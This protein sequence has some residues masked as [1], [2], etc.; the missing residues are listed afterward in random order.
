MAK[1]LKSL[2]V[3]LLVLAIAAL[4]LGNML[5]LQREELKGR[6]Q[7]LEL[8]VMQ[9][10][11][12]VE[13][14]APAPATDPDYP[15]RDV[16]MVAAE[17]DENPERGDFWETYY[18]DL[19]LAAESTLDLA[20]KRDQL[21]RY[22]RMDPITQKPMR[23]PVTREKVTD[24][25]DTMQALLDGVIDKASGQLDRLNRTRHE[26]RKT[27][28]ELV[29]TVDALN[30]R[31]GELRTALV[32]IVDRDCSITRLEDTVRQRDGTIEECRDEIVMLGDTIHDQ[33][34][35]L[36]DRE[37]DIFSLNQTV[38]AQQ[39]KIHE[40]ESDQKNIVGVNREWVWITRGIKGNIAAI[41]EEMNFVVIEFSTEFISE[42]TRALEKEATRPDPDMLV[43]RSQSENPELFV[44]KVKLCHVNP[45]TCL[46][47]ATIL[48]GWQQLQ[49]LPG[50]VV[51]Y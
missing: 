30:T 49:I 14:G 23:D 4:T 2:V 26:L 47:V 44:T 18:H 48:T 19:E 27:R 15:K 42:Y 22:F 13:A 32:A 5:F 12:T 51:A 24:G 3:V 35:T 25:P 9:M 8:A 16:G 6:T 11:T 40:L 39:R 17:L 1:L 36:E 46:G 31:K 10:A 21:M 34:V 33:R 43:W 50:D 41:D 45:K 28:G 20:P 38:Q 29:D 7:K 37:E